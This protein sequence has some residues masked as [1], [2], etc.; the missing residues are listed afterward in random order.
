MKEINTPLISI[1]VPVYNV[2]QYLP[3]CIDSILA[4]TY[5]NFEVLLINDGSPDNCGAICD[6]YAEQDNR[7]RVFHKENEGVSSA[8]N[9]GL[10]KAIGEW[11]SF[12]DSDDWVE[13]EYLSSFINQIELETK[14]DLIFQGYKK[15]YASQSKEVRLSAISYIDMTDAFVNLHINHDF[16]GYTCIKLY[17]HSVIKNNR[18]RF[19]KDITISEDLVFSLQYIQHCRKI[20]I[21]DCCNYNYRQDNVNSLM[22][23]IYTYKQISIQHQA[24]QVEVSKL[25]VLN[26]SQRAALNKYIVN[27][28]FGRLLLSYKDQSV[29]NNTRRME[30]C[31]LKKNYI[32]DIPLIKADKIHTKIV[33]FSL[34]YLYDD[35]VSVLLQCMYR[36]KSIS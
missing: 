1:I 11:I 5:T 16:F 31:N 19:N 32:N 10:D 18:L 26:I 15:I 22:R 4:Q 2:E 8:R 3:K 27:M 13:Q 23:R 29:S 24:L 28:N 14:V 17:R 30:L 35:C 20:V 12:I 7:I 33:K 36:L 34:Q 25:L 9:I 6:R 21:L